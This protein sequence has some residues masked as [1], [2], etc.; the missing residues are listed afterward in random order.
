MNPYTMERST[1]D[2]GVIWF[3]F[4]PKGKTDTLKLRPDDYQSGA[5]MK[6]YVMAWI[7]SL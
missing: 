2:D 1:D 3:T 4:T 7:A 6:A 5:A